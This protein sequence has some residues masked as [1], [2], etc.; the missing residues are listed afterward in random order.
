MQRAR[1]LL[2]LD[3]E[4]LGSG[5]I[6]L[7]HGHET[8]RVERTCQGRIVGLS[9]LEEPAQPIGALTCGARGPVPKKRADHRHAD[10]VVRTVEAMRESGTHIV[11]LAIH[12]FEPLDDV[13]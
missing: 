4:R 1:L 2:R 11:G 6:P 12:S 10:R 3:K 8:S 9:A 5:R 7:R 13:D